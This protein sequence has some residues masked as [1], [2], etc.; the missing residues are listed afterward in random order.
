M[1]QGITVVQQIVF[2]VRHERKKF[3]ESSRHVALMG[4]DLVM[5]LLGTVM[6]QA[7]TDR[8]PWGLCLEAFGPDTS[9]TQTTN[10]GMGSWNSFLQGM[11]DLLCQRPAS[12]PTNGQ[13]LP[14]GQQIHRRPVRHSSVA[15]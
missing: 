2:D 8:P 13:G 5:A 12:I 3:D 6:P 10:Q 7:E 14:D 1:K 11:K 4:E 9:S 15:Y